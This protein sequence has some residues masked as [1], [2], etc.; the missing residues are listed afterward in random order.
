MS[1]IPLLVEHERTFCRSEYLT[2]RLRQIGLSPAAKGQRGQRASLRHAALEMA[3][4]ICDEYG[5]AIDRLCELLRIDRHLDHAGVV[6]AVRMCACGDRLLGAQVASRRS[7]IHRSSCAGAMA[8]SAGDDDEAAG[9]SL[10][11]EP[12]SELARPTARWRSRLAGRAAE[13]VKEKGPGT[14]GLR[15]GLKSNVSARGD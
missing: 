12:R 15:R 5:E 3:C 1:A 4:A 8:I 14:G 10:E 2:M 13:H 7:R 6:R 9:L 11:S